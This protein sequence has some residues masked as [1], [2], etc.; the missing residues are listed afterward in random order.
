MKLKLTYSI[1]EVRPYINWIY[2]DYAWGMSSGPKEELQKLHSDAAETLS[3]FDG[4]YS[5]HALFALLDANGDGDDIVLEGFRLPLLRQQRAHNGVCLCL[6]DYLR[7][8]SS[9]VKD[10]LGVFATSVDGSLVDDNK[11]DDYQRM[12]AQTLAD[13][14][15]EAAA[16][17]LHTQV[18]RTYWGYASDEQLSISD[19][20]KGRYQG[21]R[22]AIGYPSLPD[23]SLNFML[24]DILH[25]EDIGI[26]LTQSGMMTPHASVSG[27]MFSHPEARYFEL[28][29]IGEDQ[30][31]DY[32]R[33]RGL[34]RELMRKFLQS[35]LMKP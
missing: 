23:V 24:N 21:I 31:G 13:R 7:P 22:P 1:Q 17:L 16:E 12:M 35:S 5:C 27:L 2:F 6:S 10:R 14:L 25:M 11:H 29:K 33:R 4:K 15:A 20:L 18:R 34:P 30:L 32:A 8:L 3:L 19:I 9:G 28:G 26:R